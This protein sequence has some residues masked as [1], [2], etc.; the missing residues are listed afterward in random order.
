[1]D[2]AGFLKELGQYLDVLNESE[3]KDILDEY[4]QH[5]DMKMENGMSEQEAIRDFGTIEELAADILEAYHVN[6][7]YRGKKKSKNVQK[8]KNPGSELTAAGRSIGARCTAV[9]NHIRRRIHDWITWFGKLLTVPYQW[10]K[11]TWA[12]WQERHRRKKE[13]RP[14]G[15][16]KMSIGEIPGKITRGTGRLLTTVVHMLCCCVRWAW[17]ACMV[18][19]IFLAGI[20]ML[21]SVFCAGTLGVL[22]LQ[23]Y[24]LIGFFIGCLGVVLCTGGITVLAYGLI[25]RRQGV[26]EHE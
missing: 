17:N 26:T 13:D 7:M 20:F 2:K 14:K 9:T 15:Q 5:I 8:E 3:Q 10:I 4:A 18:F 22:L 6:P 19:A 23:G 11:T 16:E 12:N 24:P 1:M 25:L 21:M